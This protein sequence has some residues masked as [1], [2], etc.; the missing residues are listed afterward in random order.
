VVLAL[1]KARIFAAI[2]D[3]AD[4]CMTEGE[5][6]VILVMDEV[7]KVITG[8]DALMLAIARS[9]NLAIV[10]PTQ[11]VEGVEARLGPAEAAQFLTL[12][13]SVIALQNRSAATTRVV[14]ERL[15][16]SFRPTLD[17]VPGVPTV[18]DAVAAQRAAG[19]IAAAKTQPQVAATIGFGQGGRMRDLFQ[20]INPFR[21]FRHATGSATGRI[22]G[23]NLRRSSLR[24]KSQS[25]RRT[26]HRAC[27]FHPRAG[28]AMRR[29]EAEAS[30]LKDGVL[31]NA[32]TALKPRQSHLSRQ[33]YRPRRARY[34]MAYPS[35]GGLTRVMR[36]LSNQ[37]SLQ[38]QHAPYVEIGSLE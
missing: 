10:A 26:G 30:L 2:R 36:D 19:R 4:K 8:Q 9:L 24:K 38:R 14:A 6:P 5:T 1:L 25:G 13:G 28:P 31:N 16:A 20:A 33:K 11:T 12:F 27:D 17:A 35:Q 29:H 32:A 21:L 3:R 34:T 22:R 7:R 15:S 37:G 23:F 18:H